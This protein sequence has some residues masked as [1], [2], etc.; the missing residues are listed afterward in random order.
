MGASLVT[1]LTDTSA[2]LSVTAEHLPSIT[3]NME[4]ILPP[5]GMAAY[6][7]RLPKLPTNAPP[8]YPAPGIVPEAIA[9]PPSWTP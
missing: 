3:E 1:V 7:Q 5:P 2:P 4:V 6:P 8:N 9:A